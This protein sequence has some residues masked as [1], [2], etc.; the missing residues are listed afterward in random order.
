MP[1]KQTDKQAK[2]KIEK[3]KKETEIQEVVNHYF[4]SKGLSL[5][6][7]KENSKKRKIIYSR[8]T[9][10]A[11][12]LIELA[13]STKK[14]KQ[15]ISIVAE[16]ANSRNLDYT[17]ETVF[18]KWLE[19]GRLKPKEIVKKPFFQNQPMVWSS[20]KKKWFVIDD[21]GEWL[22]FAGKEKDIEWQIDQPKK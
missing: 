2:N 12:E 14:A 9:R 11:K 17:I 6:E 8:F 22:E 3:E 13:G 15:A 10:P 7:V 20:A 18:K 21:S 4:F 19:L 5:E 16:W 1:K